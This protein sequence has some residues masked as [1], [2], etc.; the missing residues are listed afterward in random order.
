[1]TAIATH[2][3]SPADGYTPCGAAAGWVLPSGCGSTPVARGLEVQLAHEVGGGFRL[4]ELQPLALA[5][6]FPLPERGQHGDR[7]QLPRDVVGVVERGAA[8]IRRVGWF[9]SRCTPLKPGVQR[10]VGRHLAEGAAAAV[11]LR[12][13]VDHPGLRARIAS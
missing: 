8:R 2:S 5:A 12:R 4:R 7:E 10:A 13:D 9:H 1:M 6:R 11:A 3:S